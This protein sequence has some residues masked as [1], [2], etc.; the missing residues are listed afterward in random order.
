MD[1]SFPTPLRGTPM[2]NDISTT[3]DVGALHP[4]ADATSTP[5]VPLS[6]LAMSNV[7]S[8]RRIHSIARTSRWL[9]ERAHARG[10]G[11]GL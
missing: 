10:C 4:L 2:P 5:V 9:K 1:S 6:D 3:G 11:I 8:V 7:R